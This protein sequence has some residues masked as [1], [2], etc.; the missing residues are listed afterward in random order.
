VVLPLPRKPVTS[1]IGIAAL[2]LSV[3]GLPSVSDR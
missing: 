3:M 1:V 2:A